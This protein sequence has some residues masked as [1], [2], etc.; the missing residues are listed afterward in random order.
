MSER[1]TKRHLTSDELRKV[2]TFLEENGLLGNDTMGLE[3]FKKRGELI[4][5]YAP[6]VLGY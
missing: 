6:I 3:A 2:L 4:R 5:L 1:K